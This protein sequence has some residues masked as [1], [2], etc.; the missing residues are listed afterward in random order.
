MLVDL[1]MRWFRNSICSGRLAIFL[2]LDLKIVKEDFSELSVSLFALNHFVS[3]VMINLH[4]DLMSSA[5]LLWKNIVVSSAKS[6]VCP[7]GQHLC[8]SFIN[9]IK[10]SGPRTEPWGTPQVIGRV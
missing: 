2:L 6:L 9:R 3:W 4:L 5:V 8:K 10:K 7:S 1:K